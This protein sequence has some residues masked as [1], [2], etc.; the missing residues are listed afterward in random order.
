MD[1]V[2]SVCVTQEES[3]LKDNNEA[4]EEILKWDAKDFDVHQGFI[5][6][7]NWMECSIRAVY[8]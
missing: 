7:K 5:D 8:L 2:M 4:A 6:M 3:T 1:Q